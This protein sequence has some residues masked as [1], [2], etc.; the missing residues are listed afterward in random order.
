MKASNFISLLLILVLNFFNANSQTPWYHQ[1]TI[2]Q[3][4]P[5]SF[6]DSNGDGIGD[7]QG[8]IQKLDYIRSLGFET[9]WISPFFA[10]PQADFG[11]DISDY[12]S[13]SPEY[14][15]LEDAEALIQAV[16]DREM[17]IVFDMVMNH[18]SDQHE[19]FLADVNRPL[20]ERGPENDFYL[21]RDRPNNWKAMIGGKAWHWHPV[22]QQYYYAAFLPFQPDLNY[23]NPRVKAAMFGH[24]RF[25]L[26]KGVDGFRLDIFN[27]VYE[28]E[29]FRNN[30]FSLNL[31]TGFQ[32]PVHS[33]NQAE[34]LELARD[35]RALC[36]SFGDRMLIGEIIGDRQQ[37]RAYC[38]EAVN[39]RLTLA[40]NFEMLHFKWRAPYFKKL[41]RLQE[42]TF[43][44]PFMPVYVFSNHDRRR[45][46]SRLNGDMEKS[47]LLQFFQF[48]VRGVPC[49]YYGEEIGMQDGRLA[50]Q[51]ALDPIPAYVKIP[52]WMANLADETLNRD[53][54]RTP[55]QWE[56]SRNAGF[57]EGDST[58][59][60]VNDDFIKI[61]V[62]QQEAW[63]GSK[64]VSLRELLEL[65]NQ[66]AALKDGNLKLEKDEKIRGNVLSFTR[67]EGDETYLVLL[68]FG[69]W[70][71]EIRLEGKWEGTFVL[72]QQDEF[73]DGIAHLGK[74]G[75][76]ILRKLN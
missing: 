53:E 56:E 36:D 26:E 54:L 59:L 22:R 3:I 5:R 29:N 50:Y 58:W 68:N 51:T 37:S 31:L 39:D 66:R 14:G 44:R 47:R 2:Y 43:P 52:R 12:R 69:K 49:L 65:R 27:S 18:T 42:E 15:T 25:W 32:K 46:M 70:K 7:L 4:Y 64:L 19:W 60:P 8:I 61:N 41:I 67:N 28:R 33:S 35:L 10:S 13:I 20:E 38:G 30:P 71:R 23:R 62:A 17:R 48:T 16:H 63:T 11:Y 1:T 9:I 45:S 76:L 55:M 24:V 73:R 6:Y 34:S 74:Y 21:W 57:T 72:N 40:F 75:G